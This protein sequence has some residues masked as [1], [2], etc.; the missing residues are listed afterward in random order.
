MEEG[1]AVES[2]SMNRKRH[3][4]FRD[5]LALVEL[6]FPHD[7]CMTGGQLNDRVRWNAE[8]LKDW[9]YHW[10]LTFTSSRDTTWREGNV[11]RWPELKIVVQ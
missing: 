6:W 2:L 5:S 8:W 7:I 9:R 3:F 4:A 11:S 10:Y 1:T